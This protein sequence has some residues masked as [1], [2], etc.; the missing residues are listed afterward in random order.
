MT[1]RIFT[2]ITGR[3]ATRE[4]N[5]LPFSLKELRPDQDG[6]VVIDDQAVR[7]EQVARPRGPGD[8]P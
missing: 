2:L 6:E 8:L 7:D 1:T 5:F 4:N 3:R